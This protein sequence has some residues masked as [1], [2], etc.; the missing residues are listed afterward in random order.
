TNTSVD[1]VTVNVNADD[2]APTANA[3]TDL[4]AGEGD[5]VTLDA[6]G[7]S[8]PE[9]QSLSYTWT[10][11][12]GP[13]VTLSDP[14]AAQPTFDAPEGVSNT[15]LTFQVQVSD[16]TN[17]SVDTVTVNVNADDDADDAGSD[18]DDDD[19]GAPPASPA[20]SNQGSATLQSEPAAIPPR[21]S[22]QQTDDPS[23]TGSGI[24]DGDAPLEVTIP[25]GQPV[26]PQPGPTQPQP[27]SVEPEPALAGDAVGTP[28]PGGAQS[29]GVP[30]DG[31]P[32]PAAGPQQPPVISGQQS[33]DPTTGGSDTDSSESGLADSGNAAATVGSTGG[34][35]ARNKVDWD[36]SEDLKVLD[37]ANQI[38]DALRLENSGAAQ[39]Q[40]DSV[41]LFSVIAGSQYESAHALAQD[42]DG[43]TQPS[44]L[45][46]DQ[47]NPLGGEFPAIPAQAT[48][49]NFQDVY[50]EAGPDNL[51]DA[52]VALLH[53][54]GEA[55]STAQPAG[56]APVQTQ[57][58][59]TV[60]QLDESQVDVP[61]DVD[62]ALPTAGRR[63][64]LLAALWAL[65]RGSGGSERRGEDGPITASDKKTPQRRL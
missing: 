51:P 33:H 22:A 30:T 20:S 50:L 39:A 6:S 52:D 63:S 17:T 21:D 26:N 7:S 43:L 48:E 2:D 40:A 31:S 3:G 36:G 57:R 41:D 47:I 11:T 62:D 45:T 60:S 13:S 61:A 56:D 24:D 32:G 42:G 37:P 10:Q 9:G 4:T 64:G 8:D 27:V 1:T 53:Q 38:A 23:P 35:Q 25:P 34:E 59:V 44:E 5:T 14:S 54:Q 16:G 15:P 46:G 55:L 28:S 19:A 65:V 49:L 18:T 29:V 12:G 58:E